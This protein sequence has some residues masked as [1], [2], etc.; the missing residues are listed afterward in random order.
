MHPSLSSYLIHDS[1]RTVTILKQTF[2]GPFRSFCSLQ[3]CFVPTL[4]GSASELRLCN[5]LKL[6]MEDSHWVTC[7][8]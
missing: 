7:G 4:S 5:G 2:L 3:L 1:R 6:V 8:I